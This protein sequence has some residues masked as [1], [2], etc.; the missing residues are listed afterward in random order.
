M[1][2]LDTLEH[3][4][5]YFPEFRSRRRDGS[6]PQT[7][8]PSSVGGVSSWWFLAEGLDDVGFC[9]TD[10][11][12]TTSKGTAAGPLSRYYYLLLLLLAAT[13]YKYYRSQAAAACSMPGPTSTGHAAGFPSSISPSS[14]GLSGGTY[15]ALQQRRPRTNT[16]KP[17]ASALGPPCMRGWMR[18]SLSKCCRIAQKPG[19]R[20]ASHGARS[21]TL[22]AFDNDTPC[23]VETSTGESYLHTSTIA[24]QLEKP[25]AGWF[26]AA[27]VTLRPSLVDQVASPSYCN[28][29]EIRPHK[30]T[31][32]PKL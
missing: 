9:I 30:C 28:A 20:C 29:K 23:Q 16:C 13:Y 32:A 17:S 1:D 19:D 21:G 2:T 26:F 4:D 14:T 8:V 10:G 7:K 18:V 15:F 6:L 24:L 5:R 22:C 11:H 3:M 25:L 12:G 31:G 27:R